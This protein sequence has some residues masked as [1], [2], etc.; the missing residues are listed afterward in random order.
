[1]PPSPL[2]LF[3]PKDCKIISVV[4]DGLCR[5]AALYHGYSVVNK[6]TFSSLTQS[7]HKTISFTAVVMK[8]IDTLGHASRLALSSIAKSFEKWVSDWASY[9]HEQED[10][11]STHTHTTVLLKLARS[12][13]NT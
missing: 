13:A 6:Q 11:S 9:R 4:D 5:S 8:G 12:L 7:T 1:M 2:V 3:S 10:L